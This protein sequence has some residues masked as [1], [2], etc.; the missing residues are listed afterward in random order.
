[1]KKVTIEDKKYK[2]NVEANPLSRF[3]DLQMLTYVLKWKRGADE[4]E[5]T[6]QSYA[7]VPF[8]QSIV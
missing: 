4:Y 6:I 2:W 5:M 3:I 8:G 1:M 7:K